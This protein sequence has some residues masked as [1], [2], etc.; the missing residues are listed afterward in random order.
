MTPKATPR[1]LY[2]FVAIFLL[3]LDKS[4][5]EFGKTAPNLSWLRTAR[6]FCLKAFSLPTSSGKK[7][8]KTCAASCGTIWSECAEFPDRATPD[9][10]LI[11]N[12]VFTSTTVK[13]ALFLSNRV[14]EI[15]IRL[16]L[17]RVWVTL[18]DELASLDRKTVSM[19]ATVVPEAS[20]LRTRF[21]PMSRGKRFSSGRKTIRGAPFQTS[22]GDDVFKGVFDEERWLYA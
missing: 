1:C 3:S 19:V 11:M 12:E 2:F 13:D 14:M 21:W 8:F 16:D 5:E 18:I 22:F 6:V 15:I 17:F 4:C 7:P 20:T 9:S 10:I